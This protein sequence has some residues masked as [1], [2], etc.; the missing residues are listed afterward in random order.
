MSDLTSW[1]RKLRWRLAQTVPLQGRTQ[2][3][4]GGCTR[5]E[6]SL[7][8]SSGVFATLDCTNIVGR[9]RLCTSW[10]CRATVLPASARWVVG[11]TEAAGRGRQA[12][13]PTRRRHHRWHCLS[14][15]ALALDDSR[16]R[17]SAEPALSFS[18]C[19]CCCSVPSVVPAR[20]AP[21]RRA[22]PLMRPSVR[23]RR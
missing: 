19:C 11:Q 16:G 10:Y 18:A 1:K 14:R 12:S 20:V 7:A 9:R 3:Q 21:R 17:I 22:A 5:P 2:A 8:P 15:V 6:F 23:R 13:R 4:E